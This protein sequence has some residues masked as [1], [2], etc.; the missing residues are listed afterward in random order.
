MKEMVVRGR[1]G[2]PWLV[3]IASLAFTSL[4]V[5]AQVITDFSPSF[6]QPGTWVTL[7][8]HGFYYTGTSVDPVVAVQ[9]GSRPAQFSVTA[10]SQL[11]AVVPAGATTDYIRV[12][13]NG[14]G[15]VYSPRTFAVIGPGPYISSFSPTYGNVGTLVTIEGVQFT[16]ATAVRFNGV[17]APGFFVAADTR[18]QVNVPSG[19]STGP[20]SVEQAGVGTNVSAA[21]FYLPPVVESFDPTNGRA[22]TV[23]TIRGRN[24]LGT[25]AVHFGS[26]NA[27]FAPPSTNTMLQAVVPTGARSAPIRLT[28]PG[29][30]YVTASN[31]IVRPTLTG[32]SPTAGPPGTSVTLSGANLDVTPVT[33]RFGGVPA[34]VTQTAFDRLVVTVPFGAE[35]APISV[36][37]ADGSDTSP[38]LFHLPPE[39]TGFSPTNGPPGTAVTLQ[40]RNLLGTTTV[41]FGG[42]PAGFAPPSRNTNLIA[43]V[44]ENVA[45]GPLTV[46]TPGGT[47]NTGSRWFYG[48]PRIDGF[49]PLRGSPGTKVLLAGWNFLGTTNVRLGGMQAAFQTPT[50]N[51]ALVVTVPQGAQAGPI[52][53][54]TPGGVSVSAASFLV[55]YLAD[56]RLE[57]PIGIVQTRVSS[58]FN[59]TLTFRNL[60]PHPATN[61][62]LEVGWASP[63][64]LLSVAASAGTVSQESGRLR[65]SLPSLSLH[66]PVSITLV[67]SALA[68]GWCTNEAFLF[69]G[70]QDPSPDNARWSQLVWIEDLARLSIQGLPDR[71]VRIS[72]PVTLTNYALQF[73]PVPG[74]NQSWS[75]HPTA[76]IVTETERF[77]LEPIQSTGRMYRLK[78]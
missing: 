69:S 49:S 66:Q 65:V 37:T 52:E 51:T 76:P 2:V 3:G 77:I 18:I 59:A 22:G 17:L 30:V 75:D 50:N 55:D 21:F 25:M 29:G 12:A 44:P 45:T 19:A 24:L 7:H 68:S 73:V 67:W 34:A 46:V 56:L 11:V 40:G 42:V 43:Y 5:S 28:T 27:S 1:G 72:W 48:T 16:G 63:L 36:T 6:G 33:V 70:N 62:V 26:L 60:G 20:I 23:V 35:T 47:T 57:G 39:L 10:D 31:F 54:F 15:W 71:R 74:G 38:G 58:N 13:K 8:G 61:V 78:R 9:F 64:S 41:L 32:F 4:S 53:V 14:R